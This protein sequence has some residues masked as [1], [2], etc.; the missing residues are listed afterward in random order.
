M[1]DISENIKCFYIY[2]YK[3]ILFIYLIPRKIYN[4]YLTIYYYLE[5]EVFLTLISYY[6][7]K[8]C[9]NYII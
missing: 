1:N 6:A 7:N 3:N 2:Q 9:S 8:N 5:N 4:N